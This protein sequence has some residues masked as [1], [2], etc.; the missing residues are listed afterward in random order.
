[1]QQNTLHYQTELN[2]FGSDSSPKKTT[3]QLHKNL[4]VF[5][6]DGEAERSATLTD[7]KIGE[8]KSIR[9][10]QAECDT[11]QQ[12]VE[13]DWEKKTTTKNH[14]EESIVA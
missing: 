8:E 3:T 4:C 11:C 10:D 5:N 7:V 9:L 12:E 6:S 1:M 2:Q 13:L 14:E